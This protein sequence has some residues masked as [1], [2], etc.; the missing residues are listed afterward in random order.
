MKH[1]LPFDYIIVA[2]VCFLIAATLV[3]L[4]YTQ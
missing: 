2:G 1:L 4:E 3:Y